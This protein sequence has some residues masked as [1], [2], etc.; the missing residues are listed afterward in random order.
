M[1]WIIF[2]I[3][4]ICFWVIFCIINKEPAWVG[5]CIATIVWCLLTF[6]SAIITSVYPR[7]DYIVE[8]TPISIGDSYIIEDSCCIYKD[9]EK[10]MVSID[11]CIPSVDIEKPAVREIHLA[12][13]KWI[14][15]IYP[16]ILF[17]YTEYELVI[18]LTAD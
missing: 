14:T 15:A 4:L 3:A 12:A 13:P 9:K 8:Y 11:R 17:E 7:V 10:I 1:G 18:P 6:A 5:L 16:S 2:A